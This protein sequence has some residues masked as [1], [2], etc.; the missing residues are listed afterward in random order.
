MDTLWAPKIQ[1]DQFP[2][3]SI[4]RKISAAVP[5]PS[6]ITDVTGAHALLTQM[7]SSFSKGDYVLGSQRIWDITFVYFA[8]SVICGFTFFPQEF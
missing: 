2:G 4:K 5:A 3:L 8:L 1:T 7:R 6:L